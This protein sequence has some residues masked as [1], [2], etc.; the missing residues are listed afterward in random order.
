[1]RHVNNTGEDLFNLNNKELA[2]L[3]KFKKQH[4]KCIATR[5][6]AEVDQELFLEYR[7]V[8][9]TLG[10]LVAVEC[11]CGASWVSED[12]GYYTRDAPLPKQVGDEELVSLVIGDLL[13]VAKRPGMHLQRRSLAQ[14]YSYINGIWKA[15]AI[16]GRE[17]DFEEITHR[18][19]QRLLNT[20]LGLS[21]VNPIWENMLSFA[22][23]EESAFL[24]WRETLL[25]CL[26]EEY[27]TVYEKY[28]S[29]NF[30][31]DEELEL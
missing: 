23:G 5:Y 22:G 15:L 6:D 18:V 8:A 1:M 4:K 2:S 28:L 24:L 26:N 25:T 31:N 9:T 7:Y 29:S 13:E 12:G 11:I 16:F 30:R 20:M 10:P 21:P 17:S 27:P 14:F 19:D 3:R